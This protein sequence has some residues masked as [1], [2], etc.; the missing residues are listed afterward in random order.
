MIMKE[1][2]TTEQKVFSSKYTERLYIDLM[3]TQDTSNYEMDV[4]PYREDYPKGSTEIIIPDN[5][6]LIIPEGR[7]LKDFENTKIIFETYRYLTPTQASDARLWTFLTHVTYWDYMKK[8]WPTQGNIAIIK[9]RY[10]LRSPNLRT[11]THNGISRLW[12]FGYL[13]YDEDRNNP[14]ELTE[15]M[16]KV[17]DLPTS[18]LERSLGSNENIR[19]AVLEY[20][21]ENPQHLTS[22]SI[23]EIIKLIN[24]LGGVKNLP[25]LEVAEIKQLLSTLKNAA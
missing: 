12:W 25:F 18:L 22:K 3:E 16:L 19:V 14:W 20:F 5:V 7:D 23:Q 8:R 13:T 4:F 15:I 9:D 1:L 2:N 17:Q 24:L 11:L 21:S 10:F 6:E